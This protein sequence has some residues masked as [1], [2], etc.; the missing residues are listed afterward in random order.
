ML[1][2]VLRPLRSSPFKHSVS[3]KEMHRG[4]AVHLR[5]PRAQPLEICLLSSQMQWSGEFFLSHIGTCPFGLET[6]VRLTSLPRCLLLRGRLRFDGTMAAGAL[7]G[8]GH[9]TRDLTCT[10]GPLAVTGVCPPDRGVRRQVN[11]TLQ[12]SQITSNNQN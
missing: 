7:P 5:E 6:R 11:E 9:V 1:T 8:G 12:N 3:G 2:P 10:A 4:H